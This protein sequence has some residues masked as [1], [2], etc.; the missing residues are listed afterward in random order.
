MKQSKNE[1]NNVMENA[2]QNT[3]TSISFE[4][5]WDLH[6]NKNKI[7]SKYRKAALIPLIVIFS[8]FSCFTIGYAGLSRLVDKTDLP[9]VDDSEVIGKWETVDFVNDI[10]DFDPKKQFTYDKLY[11]ND[12]VFIKD[13]E[14]LDRIENSNLTYSNSTWTKGVIISPQMET[15]SKYTI[16]EINGGKY[17]FM[18]W[19]SGDYVIRFM[20]PNYYVL[21]QVDAND[22][23]SYEVPKL[24]DKID[25]L[26]SNNTEMI[27]HWES[28]D[29]IEEIDDFRP[30]ILW[31]G[32]NLFLK[33]LDILENGSLVIKNMDNQNIT[34]ELSWTGD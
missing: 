24:V 1:I 3:S 5:L 19:K 9:F 20:K 26:F 28:V 11:L 16:K 2:L 32:D 13:G 15:A 23:S 10:S 17:M 6:S 31:N 14:M 29:F 4:S 12:L 18:E 30:I 21:K 34:A 27:G 33:E 25:Y 7:K 8:L 22:Y